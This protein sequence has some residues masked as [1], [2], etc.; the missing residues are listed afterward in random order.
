MITLKRLNKIYVS[1]LTI[2]ELKNILQVEYEKFVLNPNINIEVQKY[3]PITIY[4]DGEVEN[5]ISLS[6]EE[7]ISMFPSEERI[8]KLRCV[9][10]WSMVIMDSIW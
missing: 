6:M 3:R 2:Q 1:G 9:E 4:I 7:I 5:P 10:G 8:Y